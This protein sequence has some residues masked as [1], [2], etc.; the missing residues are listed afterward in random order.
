[1]KTSKKILIVIAVIIGLIAIGAYAS[2]MGTRAIN[3]EINNTKIQWKETF[4]ELND[5]VLDNL[6][7]AD[8]TLTYEYMYCLEND[9]EAVAKYELFLD[10]YHLGYAEFR[11][12]S[13]L[14]PTYYKLTT[15]SKDGKHNDTDYSMVLDKIKNQ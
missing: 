12:D 13:Y 5:M 1:M 10:G 2:R 9:K 15:I 3:E 6:K 8:P 14:D 11:I 7:T 4:L